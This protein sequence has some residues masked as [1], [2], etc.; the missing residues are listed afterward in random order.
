MFLSYRN[1]SINSVICKS[2]D[3]FLTEALVVNGLNQYLNLTLKTQEQENA[4]PVGA[5]LLKLVQNSR[6]VHKFYNISFCC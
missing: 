3:W 4:Q 2:I 1:Q 5:I 6:F